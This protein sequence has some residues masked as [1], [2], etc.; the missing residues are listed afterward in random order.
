MPEE[1]YPCFKG[2][3]YYE[4][5]P[6]AVD[7]QAVPGS[8]GSHASPSARMA[9]FQIAHDAF[10]AGIEGG[11]RSASEC[12]SQNRMCEMKIGYTLAAAIAATLISQSVEAG[13]RCGNELIKI[14]DFTGAVADK[15]GNCGKITY[16]VNLGTEEEFRNDRWITFAV[17]RWYVVVDERGGR[18]K[19][20]LT[21]KNGRLTDIGRWQRQ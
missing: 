10:S 20:P 2:K 17:T 3:G 19:Y 5:Q 14:G 6:A 8:I 16:Q 13:I 15:L 21:F 4:S 11:T 9:A 18:Y 12:Q 7:R 1:S